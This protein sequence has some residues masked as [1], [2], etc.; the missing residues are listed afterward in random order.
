M[1]E[2]PKE[3]TEHFTSR[4]LAPFMHYLKSHYSIFHPNQFPQAG[5]LILEK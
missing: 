4:T 1:I 3:L 2:I 5:R